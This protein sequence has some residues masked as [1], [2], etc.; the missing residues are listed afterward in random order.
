MKTISA[1]CI[2]FLAVALGPACA[3]GIQMGHAKG[4]CEKST[5]DSKP[6]DCTGLVYM[7]LDS[8][9]RTSL[10]F[11]TKRGIIVFSSVSTAQ[12]QL[13]VFNLDIDAM[14]LGKRRI[15][16]NGKCTLQLSSDA[17]F[18]NQATCEAQYK[19]GGAAFLFKSDGSPVSRIDL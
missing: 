18:F 15:A 17:K 11:I 2:A 5:L 1:F 8:N 7:H 14:T 9:G 12:P 13:E 19:G 16:A 10:Q 3:A 6:M 4:H